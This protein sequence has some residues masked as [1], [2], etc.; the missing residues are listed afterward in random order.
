M[1]TY[2]ESFAYDAVGNMQKIQHIGSDPAS[3][4][5]TRSYAYNEISQLEAARQNNR[6]SSTTIGATTETYSA[7]GN[8]YDPHGN[9]LSLPQLQV[10]QWDYK[11][12]LQVT[13][14]QRVNNDDT[15]GAQ[16]T[17]ERT[18]Y[19]YDSA[20]Q[21]VRKV[22]EGQ[23]GSLV[24]ERIYI[25]SFEVYREYANTGAITLE[26][27]NLQVMDDKQRVALVETRTKGNDGTPHQLVR[28]EFGN[29]LGSASLELD[30]SGNVISYEEYYPYGSTSYQAVSQAIKAASKHYRYIGKE[31]D[32]ETGFYYCGARY[33]MP[34]L[35]RW[36]NGDPAGLVDG[37]D[38]YRYARN[39]PVKFLGI[40]TVWIQNVQPDI[41]RKRITKPPGTETPRHGK[42][43][44]GF[45][46]G[47]IFVSSA[48]SISRSVRQT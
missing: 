20:G 43:N 2:I 18:Y 37:T 29:H 32:E 48:T 8:G 14:R 40:Q 44:E 11:D 22:T 12:Q 16:H 31:R 33:Y 10:M 13:Q 15:D 26:K 30:D 19:V 9:M 46:A 27:R 38:L 21:R 42:S 24:K 28:Y 23:Q 17:G 36:I 25:G 35:A 45:L 4:G 5:W 41:K 6:L 47:K 3:P 7:G 39:N 34:W 1:G